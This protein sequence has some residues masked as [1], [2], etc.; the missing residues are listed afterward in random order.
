MAAIAPPHIT[1]TYPEETGD[2]ALLLARARRA[3]RCAV[4]FDVTFGAVAADDD[5]HGGLAERGRRLRDLDE[6]APGDT[7]ASVLAT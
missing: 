4:A 2:E 6:A 7:S 5:G 3:A 1:L